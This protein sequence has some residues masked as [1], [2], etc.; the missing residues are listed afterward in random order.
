MRNVF[1][2]LG[3][4]GFW[5]V[6]LSARKPCIASAVE[7]ERR[8]LLIATKLEELIPQQEVQ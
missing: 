3:V 7:T 2:S 8:H 6:G 1:G 5:D 4:S